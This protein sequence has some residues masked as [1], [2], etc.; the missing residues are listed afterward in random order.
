[1][2]QWWQLW[3]KHFTADECQIIRNEAMKLP[4]QQAAIGHG[5]GDRIDKGY[6]RSNVRWIYRVAP[7]WK[8]LIDRMDYLFQRSNNNAFGFDLSYF[9]E[10]QFTEYDSSYEGKYDW[11]E[12][13]TWPVTGR[14]AIHRKLSMVIQ[15]TDPVEYEGGNLELKEE[16]P[17]VDELRQLGT[18]I[19]FP[20]FLEHRVVPVTKGTRYSLVS[21][22]EGPKFR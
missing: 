15:L 4:V 12:D 17:A 14:S 19:V 20:S 8:W 16:P 1:M 18:V 22:Y 21:W 7:Q 13:L 10:I 9:H 11:H 2:N 3:A 6:R 5:G